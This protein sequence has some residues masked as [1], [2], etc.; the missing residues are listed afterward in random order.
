V[1]R[2]HRA[3]TVVVQT[4]NPENA[5]LQAAVH[6]EWQN[7]YDAELRER[8]T[9]HFPPFTYLLK[10][11]V[12]RASS[13]SAQKAAATFAETLA[14]DFPSVTVEGPAPSFHPRI[15]SKYSWQLLIKSSS[16]KDLVAIVMQLPSGWS[17]D[18]DPV[19]LL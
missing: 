6:R 16:R 11:R 18:I 9:Y 7:F 5:T 12:L 8:K 15:D 2:G 10:L 17:Y 19:N 4:Y 14:K 3:S 1:G 13:Q